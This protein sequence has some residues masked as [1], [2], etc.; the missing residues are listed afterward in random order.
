MRIAIFLISLMLPGG[1]ALANQLSI[2]ET[3]RK[4]SGWVST[5]EYKKIFSQDNAKNLTVK[6]TYI[7]K[8][9]KQNIFIASALVNDNECSVRFNGYITVARAF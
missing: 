2:E 1:S 4:K 8:N 7:N 5:N 6:F 3:T 9:G